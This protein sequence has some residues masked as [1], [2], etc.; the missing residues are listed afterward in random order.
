MCSLHQRFTVRLPD[1]HAQSSLVNFAKINIHRTVCTRSNRTK[2][3]HFVLCFS[4]SVKGFRP[5]TLNLLVLV[6]GNIYLCLQLWNFLVVPK[7]A[8]ATKILRTLLH[9]I[10]LYIYFVGLLAFGSQVIQRPCSATDH[11]TPQRYNAPLF[12]PAG[13]RL[14]SLPSTKTHTHT[15]TPPLCPLTFD[16]HT[17]HTLPSN[18]ACGV[19]SL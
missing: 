1:V 9:L 16:A 7:C 11:F 2:W 14:Q 13:Q 19:E 17:L 10:N 3:Q 12:A 6:Q 15:P 5:S 8:A 18:A 4:P